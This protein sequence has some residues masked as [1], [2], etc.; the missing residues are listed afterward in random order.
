MNPFHIN[1]K[2][3]LGL[4][5]G[6][7]QAYNYLLSRIEG[8]IYAKCR[9]NGLTKYYKDIRQHTL[10]ILLVNLENG[11]YE[12]DPNTSPVTYTIGI[13]YNVMRNQGRDKHVNLLDIGAFHNAFWT[14]NDWTG[15]KEEVDY[16]LSFLGETCQKLIRLRKLEGYP[17]QEIIDRNL[18]PQLGSA[19][20][21]GNK[22]S[23]CWNSWM[24][25]IQRLQS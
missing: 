5:E 24:T 19:S 11:S 6:N 17:Y 10:V 23:A 16:Y 3:Y 13:A 22:F 15:L 12:F 7:R 18:L 4:K 20:A 8:P 2:L 21:L 25:I 1:E 14:Q 9:E